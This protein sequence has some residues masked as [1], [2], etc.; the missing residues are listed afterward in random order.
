MNLL[1]FLGAG[2]STEAGLPIQNEFLKMVFNMSNISQ[3][4]Y[5]AISAAYY[6]AMYHEEKKEVNMEEAFC[7]LD[8]RSKMNDYQ[9]KIVLQYYQE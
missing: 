1:L 2:F 6:S 9:Y 4:Q 3:E 7:L 5:N 8:F